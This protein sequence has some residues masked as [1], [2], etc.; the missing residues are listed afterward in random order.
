M[1][2]LVFYFLALLVFPVV[3]IAQPKN[4]VTIYSGWS[5][6]G[7]DSTRETCFLCAVPMMTPGFTQVETNKLGSSVLFGFKYSRSLNS[8]M[9]IEGN[10]SVAP[11][12]KLESTS[13]IN[14][15]PGEICPLM[16]EPVPG[17]PIYFT[18][19]NMVSYFYDV[20]FVYQFTTGQAVPYVLAG[21]GAVS[22]DPESDIQTDLTWVFGGGAKFYLRNNVGVRFEVN[23]HLIPGY[24]LTDKTEN[25][26]QIQYGFIFGL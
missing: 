16:P 7:I 4:E 14:C 3:L 5:F 8:R 21:V 25:N 13:G 19:R 9:A 2:R 20:S 23:D 17:L 26:L 12:Q 15:P 24:F 22:S 10:F 1:R 11:H 18:Q 6:P